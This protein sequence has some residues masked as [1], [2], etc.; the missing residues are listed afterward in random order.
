[1][2][3]TNNEIYGHAIT[4]SEVFSDNTQKFPMKINFCLQKNKK[5]LINLGQDIEE[6]RKQIFENYGTLSEDGDHYMILSENIDVAQRELEDLLNLEQEVNIC[7]IPA[8]GLTNDI[9]L[10]AAQME[11]LMF[12]IE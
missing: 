4:L 5:T 3:M 7:M 6:A 2:K 11:A 8:E 12:M 1:M 9:S 10:T